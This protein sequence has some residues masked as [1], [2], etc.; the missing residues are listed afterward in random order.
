[1]VTARNFIAAGVSENCTKTDMALLSEIAM[2]CEVAFSLIALTSADRSFDDLNQR[3]SSVGTTPLA[4]ARARRSCA[5]DCALCEVCE[6]RRYCTIALLLCRLAL[7]TAS[8]PH[9]CVWVCPH[10][11]RSRTTRLHTRHMLTTHARPRVTKPPHPP[12]SYSTKSNTMATAA[13]NHRA[14]GLL[15]LSIARNTNVGPRCSVLYT[16]HL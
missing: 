1:M 15:D 8:R 16:G 12:Q 13:N 9:H 2:R 7:W 14:G 10:A 4:S 11:L 3:V 5:F 6:G